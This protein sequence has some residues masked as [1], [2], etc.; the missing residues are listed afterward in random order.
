VLHDSTVVLDAS[1]NVKFSQHIIM[2]LA[3]IPALASL[4]A[5]HA[6]AS[7]VC[8]RLPPH[9]MLACDGTGLQKP[10]VDMG[11]YHA[12][13]QMRVMGCVKKGDSRVLAAVMPHP[14]VEF[15]DTLI[16]TPAVAGSVGAA[17]AAD[18]FLAAHAVGTVHVHAPLNH[19][20][21]ALTQWRLQRRQQCRS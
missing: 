4:A 2:H 3:P 11:V 10:I 14:G 13:Q 1:N 7:Y 5:A 18:A 19:S 16:C 20:A 21:A 12:R 17:G 15:E 6:V 8:S 9:L